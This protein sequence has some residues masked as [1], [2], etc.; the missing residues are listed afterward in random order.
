M[1]PLF[2]RE[3][4]EKKL[5][6]KEIEEE[7]VTKLYC[8]LVVESEDGTIER[9]LAVGTFILDENGKARAVELNGAVS[10]LPEFEKLVAQHV[11]LKKE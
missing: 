11:R 9:E 4:L 5:Q 3:Q 2:N 1:V 8:R 10:I 7:G 6:C